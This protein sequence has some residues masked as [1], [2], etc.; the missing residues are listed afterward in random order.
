MLSHK[1]SRFLSV[2]LCISLFMTIHAVDA[3]AACI[4]PVQTPPAGYIGQS[5]SYQVIAS[6]GVPPLTF[7]WIS[8]GNPLPPGLIISQ[9]GFI[10]GTPTEAVSYNAVLIRATGGGDVPQSC[11]Q[12]LTMRTYNQ[13]VSG[14]VSPSSYSAPSNITTTQSLAYTFTTTPFASTTMVSAQGTF[15]VGGTQIGANYRQV[16]A[17]ITGGRGTV[18]ETITILPSVMQ[19]AL[20]MGYSKMTYNRSFTNGTNTVNTQVEISITTAA[21]ADLMITRMQLY[22]Q[23]RQPVIT[24]KRNDSSLRTYAEI[25]YVGSGLLQG[26]WEVDGNFLSNVNQTITYGTAIR[27][28]S[29][30]PPILPTFTSGTHR[31][32]LVITKPSQNIPFP[33]IRYYVTSE[34]PRLVEAKKL[35]PVSLLF[36]HNK[37]VISY[38]PVTFLWATRETGIAAYFLEFYFKDE[39]KLLF[40][41]Y[42]KNPSYSLPETILK[43]FFSPGKT[44]AWK[45]KGFDTFNNVATESTLF[46]FTMGE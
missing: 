10:S 19:K 32:R 5:Y 36:P 2:L 44:Y 46:T 3:M 25:N 9:S 26:Y 13:T 22:F 1:I 30:A 45:V 6:G 12:Y 24:I 31:I 7:A 20:S 11:Q 21:A 4:M 27:I 17:N 14:S 35:T 42:T 15:Q 43:T 8:D 40:S 29:P 37:G 16:S 38:A 39:E 41:A 34:E 23:N 33:E 28:E 18:F